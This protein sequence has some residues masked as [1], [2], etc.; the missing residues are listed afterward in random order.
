MD[1]WISGFFLAAVLWVAGFRHRIVRRNLEICRVRVANGFRWWLTFAAARDFCAL[2]AGSPRYSLGPRAAKKRIL[3]YRGPSLLLTA[4]FHNWEFLG[5]A[6]RREGVPLLAA[7]LPFKNP[8]A[9]RFLSGLRRRLDLPTVSQSVPRAALRHLQQG[10]CFALL[11]D[12]HAPGSDCTG[13]FFGQPVLLNPLPVFLLR[14]HP[15]P[16]H[17]GVLLPDGELRL[18]TLLERFDGNWEYKLARRYHRVLEVLIRRQPEYWYG[19][20]HA[21]F[22]NTTRYAGHRVSK[23]L[24]V[25]VPVPG[26]R[27]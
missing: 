7:S 8:W 11:W 21:R 5:A 27:S 15:C 26:V 20:F 23:I 10:G 12:Q 17:F 6:L 22:K 18:L 4:H 16:V 3:M 25:A 2:L 1:R 14:Q 9:E 24:P 19:F 13:H